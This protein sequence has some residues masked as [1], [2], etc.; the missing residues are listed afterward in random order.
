MKVMVAFDGSRASKVAL[1]FISFIKNSI[2]SVHVVYVIP[3]ME[4]K[5]PKFD[6]YTLPEEDREIEKMERTGIGIL[7]EARKIVESM[8]VKAE[9]EMVDDPDRGIE[10]NLMVTA[11]KNGDDLIL[12]G[13]RKLGMLGKIFFDSVSSKLLRESRI[14]VLVIPP[15]LTKEGIKE[16]EHDHLC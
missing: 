12:V 8:H 10:E 3:Y 5:P 7:S 2:N 15:R 9:F 1:E 13:Q 11:I 16:I 14:P 4:K 6:D